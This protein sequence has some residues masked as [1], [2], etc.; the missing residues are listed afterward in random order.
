M[1]FTLTIEQKKTI[2]EI[3]KKTTTLEDIVDEL[4]ESFLNGEQ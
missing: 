3:Q 1:V 2:A 4:V